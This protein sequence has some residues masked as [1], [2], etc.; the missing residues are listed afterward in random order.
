MDQPA[1]TDCSRDPAR[2]A[3]FRQAVELL[4]G[5][6][7]TARRLDITESS[8]RRL[9]SDGTNSRGIRDGIIAD[10]RKLLEQHAEASLAHARALIAEQ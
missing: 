6:R 7:E 8:I 3:W 1:T 2:R 9:L 10:T 5:A 4:G